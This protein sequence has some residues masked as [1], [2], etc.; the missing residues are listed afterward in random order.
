[1]THTVVDGE[2]LSGIAAANGLSTETL[3]SWNGI[4]SDTLLISGTTLSVPSLAET[5]AAGATTATD[6][7]AA[8]TTDPATT[9][10]TTTTGIAPASWLGSIPSPWGDL[11]LDAG[12]AAAWNA[13]R[14][15]ALS[16]YGVDL[17]PAGPLSAYRT[18]TQQ[19]EMYELFLS[20]AGAPANP[21][22]MSSHELGVSVDLA[23]PEM[24]TVVD[25]IGGIYGWGK[26]EAPNEWWHVT[27]AGG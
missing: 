4:S 20:G 8:T 10:T 3:A 21:P 27:W 2:T 6:P 26:Y 17:Y 16:D 14:Q 1:M 5:G 15:Q 11:Y 13:M 19:G 18:S 22:G 12:A 9:T 24:R 23:T 7:A 25:A